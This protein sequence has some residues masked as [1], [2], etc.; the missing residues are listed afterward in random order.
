[1]LEDM[2][3]PAIQGHFINT[4][5]AL[6]AVSQVLRDTSDASSH[7]DVL[8]FRRDACTYFDCKQ[9]MTEYQTAK[10]SLMGEI[11]PFSG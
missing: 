4:W 9:S 5:A 10:Q 6:R 1:M 7:L 8:H 11:G 3:L 2:S